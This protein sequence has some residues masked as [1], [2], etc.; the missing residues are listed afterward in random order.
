MAEKA[1]EKIE[2]TVDDVA[3]AGT[4]D[5]VKGKAQELLGE[6]QHKLGIT[7]EDPELIARGVVNQADGQRKQDVGDLKSELEAIKDRAKELLSDATEV[8]KDKAHE[9]A[10]AIK[11]KVHHAKEAGE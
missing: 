8:I 9:T 7:L 1:T 11:T 2:E 4:T 3:G 6:A 10:E 5:K